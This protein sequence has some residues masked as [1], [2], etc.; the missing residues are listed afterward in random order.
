MAESSIKISVALSIFAIPFEKTL[1]KIATK[2][3]IAVMDITAVR[4]TLQ[5]LSSLLAPKLLPIKLIAPVQTIKETAKITCINGP[6]M[7]TLAIAL[8]PANL[9]RNK[10]SIIGCAPL[11]TIATIAG[12]TLIANTFIKLS[13]P[14]LLF[15]I[16]NP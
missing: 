13:S 16:P 15:C 6:T 7:F 9:P 1:P 3:E 11:I 8:S 5:A 12:N 10:P 2:M 4:N 14:N